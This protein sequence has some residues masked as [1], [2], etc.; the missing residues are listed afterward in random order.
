MMKVDIVRKITL[1]VSKP[2]LMSESEV[3][4]LMTLTRKYLE[5]PDQE[6]KDKFLTL[7]FFC[8][9]ALH[10]SIDRSIPAL[11]ILVK[12][13]DVIV[14]LKQTPNNDLLMQRVTKIVS[15]PLLKTELHKFFLVLGIEDK[16]TTDT[17]KWGNFLERF[18]EIILD[19]ILIL[20]DPP[21][22]RRVKPYYDRIVSNPIKEGFWTIGLSISLV[23]DNFFKGLKDPSPSSLLCLILYSSDT[24]RVVIPL[25]K[26]EILK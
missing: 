4:H 20:P 17:Y 2:E 3:L 19:C 1:L 22:S 13:N 5:Y 24:T 25:T 11:E 23:N 26:S 9:W 6:L 12:L 16:L 21:Q 10:I 8:D 15:F 7:K 14:E 18:I